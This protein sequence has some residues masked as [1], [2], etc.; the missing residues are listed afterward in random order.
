MITGALLLN[1]SKEITYKKCFLY[2]RRIFLALVIFG[3]C[4]SIVL[5]VGEGNKPSIISAF[6]NVYK[7]T[8][9]GHLWY[10]YALIGIYLTLPIFRGFVSKASK[11]DIQILLVV[12]FIFDF[13]IS[14]TNA[15]GIKS[16]F[17]VPIT[18]PIFYLILGYYLND[19]DRSLYRF[20]FLLFLICIPIIVLLA[21]LNP[22]EGNKWLT[23]DS[24]IV[25][26][27]AMSVFMIFTDIDFHESRLMW[28]IDRLCFGVYL[29]HPL[30]IQLTYRVFKITPMNFGITWLG[31]ICV[32]LFFIVA[33]FLFSFVASLIKP[34]KKY[35]L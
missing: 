33:S 21:L 17:E 9:F 16:A 14:I 28:K 30:F 35:V 19:V 15:A 11:E 31:T 1:P 24:P 6:L 12:L 5:M 34:L 8:S 7:G 3:V 27:M 22:V 13:A 18:W 4:Y 25:A 2:A 26:L 29:I 10:L 23:N 20:R 32:Y